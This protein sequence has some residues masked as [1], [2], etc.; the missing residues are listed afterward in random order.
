LPPTY[1]SS[2][3]YCRSQSSKPGTS[4]GTSRRACRRRLGPPVPPA[5]SVGSTDRCARTSAQAMRIVEGRGGTEVGRAPGAA[6]GEEEVEAMAAA[7]G[8]RRPEDARY[9]ATSAPCGQAGRVSSGEAHADHVHAAL[10][11]QPSF[12]IYSC[13]HALS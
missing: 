7:R 10:L 2:G 4:C 6:E 9:A 3:R 8:G 12:S 5:R 11:K 13:S 1:C